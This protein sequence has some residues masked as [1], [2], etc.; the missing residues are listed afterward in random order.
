MS[1]ASA[2]PPAK[3]KGAVRAANEAA[4]FDLRRRPRAGG[5]R[6]AVVVPE[7]PQDSMVATINDSDKDNRRV[8][9]LCDTDC[10][11]RP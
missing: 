9:G 8:E 3:V 5:P 10:D 6:N 7:R 4:G 2:S 1:W 11:L